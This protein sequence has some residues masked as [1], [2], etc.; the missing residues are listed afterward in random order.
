MLP[1]QKGASSKVDEMA[2]KIWLNFG[3]D[4]LHSITKWHFAN[5]GKAKKIAEKKKM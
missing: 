4:T 3:E 5:A 1:L 2:A